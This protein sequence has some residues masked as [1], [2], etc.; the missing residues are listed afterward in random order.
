M[1]SESRFI[2]KNLF[3]AAYMKTNTQW[4]KCYYT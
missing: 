4:C 1:P 2:D 3:V